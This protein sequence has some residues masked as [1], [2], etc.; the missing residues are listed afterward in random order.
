M[1]DSNEEKY[2]PISPNWDV[3]QDAWG[4][5]VNHESPEPSAHDWIGSVTITPQGEERHEF[6]AQDA[7]QISDGWT[8][9][10]AIGLPGVYGLERDWITIMHNRLCGSCFIY[11]PKANH[12]CENC[13]SKVKELVA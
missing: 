2:I 7:W 12:E 5:K 13:G 3:P 8:E 10:H 9:A 11:T 4:Y 1:Y 6:F